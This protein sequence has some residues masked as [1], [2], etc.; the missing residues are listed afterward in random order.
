[1]N[2]AP[3]PLVSRLQGT[4]RDMK[5]KKREK[6]KSFISHSVGLAFRPETLTPESDGLSQMPF[7]NLCGGV[8]EN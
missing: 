6:E 1:M 7:C 8:S 2:M 3:L 5:K 4:D